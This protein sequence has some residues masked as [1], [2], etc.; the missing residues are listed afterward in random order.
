M[1]Q[2]FY[3]VRRITWNRCRAELM[4]FTGSTEE[5]Y[6]QFLDARFAPGTEPI[7]FRNDSAAPYGK[8]LQENGEAGRLQYF[9]F[10]RYLLDADGFPVSA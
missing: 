2:Q 6:D 7:G 5:Q 9:Q 4:T 1:K 3:K 10:R 8:P